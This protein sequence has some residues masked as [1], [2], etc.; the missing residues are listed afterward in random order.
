VPLAGAL[1]LGELGALI[2][3]AD[4]LLSNN[5][6][7][8]H[9]AAALGTPV[10]DLYA[11]TNP[12]HTPWRV[13]H[14]VLNVDVP[15]RN[16]YR[17]VCDQPGHPCLLGVS[18]DDVVAAT[19]AL[20]RG[21]ER[22]AL[23]GRARRRTRRRA[24]R[25]ERLERDPLRARHH[26]ELTHARTHLYAGYQRRLSRQRRVPRA[27]RHRDRGRRR[28]AI[29]AR[30]AREAAGAVLDVEL[31]FHAIDYCLAEAGIALADVDHVAYSYDP[32]LELDRHGPSPN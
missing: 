5:S 26:Q 25:G 2:E 30:E 3:T 17:S 20:L 13:P 31:P 24:G 11:L 18:V 22:H 16:C 9:L 1:P 15:C 23:C 21:S 14:R 19:H 7:P 10:V 32:W 27:R 8:V 28:R 29:H 4:L 12:Q 6:G